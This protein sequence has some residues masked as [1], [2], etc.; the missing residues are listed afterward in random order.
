VKV[1]TPTSSPCSIDGSGAHARHAH[2]P[3]A[4]VDAEIGGH[5]DRR[6]GHRVLDAEIVERRDAR[7]A[8]DADA[9]LARQDREAPGRRLGPHEQAVD[10]VLAHARHGAAQALVRLGE[11]DLAGHQVARAHGFEVQLT[12]P[13]TTTL[14]A[15]HVEAED[16][17][18]HGLLRGRAGDSPKSILQPACAVPWTSMRASAWSARWRLRNWSAGGG[19]L[20]CAHGA[21]GTLAATL[22]RVA[23]SCAR[24]GGPGRRAGA[25][26][27]ERARVRVRL[28][29]SRPGWI[30][31]DGRPA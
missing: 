26:A 27:R 12:S 31:K 11:H 4:V 8:D 23:G 2:E 14:V 9:V 25:R 13:L 18:A 24:T 17:R 10:A 29:R 1:R 22:A 19:E 3:Q 20:G 5:G 15:F 6:S 16:L 7:V 30:R 21:R 28:R